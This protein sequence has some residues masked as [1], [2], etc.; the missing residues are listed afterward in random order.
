MG[1]RDR[2]VLAELDRML[3][4]LAIDIRLRFEPAARRSGCERVVD[5][6][7]ATTRELDK[8]TLRSLAKA[9]GECLR[10]DDAAEPM[11]EDEIHERHAGEAIQGRTR[12]A[13][14]ANVGQEHEDL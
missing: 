10:C 4:D 8:G 13:T 5:E 3:I 7:R 12:S 14:Y 9:I 1:R 11:I 2:E 6:L